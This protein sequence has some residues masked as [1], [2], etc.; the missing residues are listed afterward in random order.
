MYSMSTP[1]SILVRLMRGG[2]PARIVRRSLEDC[3]RSPSN[4]AQ[5]MAEIGQT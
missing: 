4:W 2:V 3:G 5:R 1:G